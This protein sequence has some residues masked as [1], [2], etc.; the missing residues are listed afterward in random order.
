MSTFML[1]NVPT[2][3]PRASGRR[4][5]RLTAVAAAMASALAI[6]VIAELALGIDLRAPAFDGSAETLP[7]RVQD[8]LLVSA[9]LSFAGWGFIAVL[10]W[11]T[12]RAGRVFLVIAVAALVLS[13]GTPLAG[14]G[15][16]LANRLVLISMHLAVGSVLIPV[17]YWSSPRREE[18]S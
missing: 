10:E 14:L 16:T 7:V 12:A 9:M 13:L 6:W 5:V 3:R 17:L 4:I 1:T 2:A 11:L 8:V 18:N 15:V